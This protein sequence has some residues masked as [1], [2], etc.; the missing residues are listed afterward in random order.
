MAVAAVVFARNVREHAHL[1]RRQQTV[2]HRDAQH[3]R[4]FLHIQPVLQAQR[5]EVVFGQFAGK[6]TPRL[7]AELLHP[8]GDDALVDIVISI[9]A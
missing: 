2:G 1:R 5:A 7:V 4:V 6:E 9:H 8:F 3:R